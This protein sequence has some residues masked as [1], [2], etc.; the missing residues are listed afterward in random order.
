MAGRRRLERKTDDRRPVVTDDF[1]YDEPVND[2]NENL[3][4]SFSSD[5]P[6][7]A[8]RKLRRRSQSLDADHEPDI[9]DLSGNTEEN[10]PDKGRNKVY[11]SG[12]MLDENLQPVYESGK[13][14]RKSHPVL[15]GIVLVAVTLSLLIAVGS[16]IFHRIYPVVQVLFRISEVYRSI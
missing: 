3:T 6:E 12:I 13:K 5:T 4:D 14:P 1:I 16:F 7:E 10:Q 15:R 2:I 8:V 9:P 11:S